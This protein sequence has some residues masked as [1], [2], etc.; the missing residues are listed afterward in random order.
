MYYFKALSAS[1]I[2]QK[3]NSKLLVKKKGER[4]SARGTQLIEVVIIGFVPH[5][6]LTDCVWK[7]KAQFKRR[8]F[9][10]PN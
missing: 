3:Q 5:N 1:A 6:K 4:A 9:V 8:T 10:V 7:A 2:E